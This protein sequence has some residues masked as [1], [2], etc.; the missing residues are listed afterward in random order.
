MVRVAPLN[1][2]TLPRLELLGALV[3]A[4]LASKVKKIVNLKRSCLQ[5]HWTDSKIVLFWIKGNKTRW[6]QFVANRVNE[7]TSLTDPHSWYHCAVKENPADFL[8]RGLSADCLVSNSRWWTGAEFLSDSEFPKNFQQVVPELDYLTEHEK[9]TVAQERKKLPEADRSEETVLLNSDSSSILDEL[10]QLSNNYFKVI[11]ILSYIFR[12][13]YNCRNKFKKVG[14]L[15]VAEFKES[16]IKLIKHAQ[17]SLF[18]KKEIPSCI[19]NLFPFVDVEGIV[20]VGG[21]LENA[22]VPYL[23]KHPAI[24]PKGSKLSKLYFN[25]L[26]TRLFH[27]GS[28][29]L[30][31]AVRQKFWSLSGR[32]IARKTV[33]QCVTCFKSRPLLYSQIMAKY[34]VSENIDWK[35]IPPKSPHFGGLWEAGVKSVKHHLKRAIGN[36][37]FTFEKF[38]TI[39]IQVEGILNSR[40]LTPL[41]SDADNFD[42]LTPGHFLIGRPIISTPEPSLID[43]NEN[44]LSRWEKI[45]KVVQRTWKKW[46]SDYLNTLQAR[47]KW[48]TE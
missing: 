5:Y 1:C 11:N 38:E 44:R 29:G 14:P 32:S 45:T 21:R 22:S 39:M 6:K 2:V 40:P 13:N 43:V 26:H 27:V 36:L 18:D 10:L 20:H 23:H 31:N 25:S 35:F 30:L 15:T 46:K 9:E 37:H 24:L 7:I 4:R 42:V 33:H 8:S 48:I 17:R 41:G 28:Q 19:S 34:F 16:E 47:S 12:F 3:A